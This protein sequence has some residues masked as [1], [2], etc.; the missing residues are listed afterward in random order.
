[1]LRRL[2]PPRPR[3]SRIAVAAATLGLCAVHVACGSRQ[4]PRSAAPA[5]SVATSRPVSGPP[6]PTRGLAF[7]SL[8]VAWTPPMLTAGDPWALAA[9]LGRGEVL[10]LALGPRLAGGAWE[11][12]G[13]GLVAALSPTTRVTGRR[14][15]GLL[16]VVEPSP[17]LKRPQRGLGPRG[18]P[19]YAANL[20]LH[21][22]W[23]KGQVL[24]IDDA[25]VEAGG[26]E[27]LP[28]VSVGSC[29]PA[30]QALAAGQ[31]LALAQLGPFLDHADGLL[32]TMYR[33][34]LRAFVPGFLAELEGY[35]QAQPREAFADEEQWAQHQCGRAYREQVARHAKCEGARRCPE[36][37]RVV[38]VGGAR[39]AAVDAG[40]AAGEHC[41][42]LVGRDYS[43]ELR[44]LGQSAAEAASAALSP[45]WTMLADRLGT[46]TEV[47]A[48]LEDLCTP[49][50]RRFAPADLEEARLRLAELGAALGS[51][52]FEA[53]AG[54][55]QIRDEPLYV[56]GLGP[57]RELARFEVEVTAINPGIVAGARA[58]RE[59]VLGRSL[60]RP[61]QAAAPLAVVLAGPGPGVLFFGYFYEEELFCGS[62]PPLGLDPATAP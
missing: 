51:E 27:S 34:E 2:Q 22:G 29:E 10:T 38:L 56:P 31:E 35:S 8:A 11:Q 15:A 47:H 58:L 59:F 16:E 4:A 23:P 53:S 37:P 44:R 6:P 48:T 9:A 17:D 50:R 45:E 62:L 24:A 21:D 39:I 33:A 19:H 3:P 61:A 5:A 32:A 12:R 40:A 30:M 42:A 14:S 1:M 54:R 7:P 20:K 60:C 55:W 36:A 46:L 18:R 13:V 52:V 25:E 49:R 26:W 43:A 57:T 41:P 28:A